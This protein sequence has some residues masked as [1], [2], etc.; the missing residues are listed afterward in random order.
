MKTVHILVVILF[1]SS[2]TTAQK[3][4][5]LKTPDTLAL[6]KAFLKSDH[7][8]N[9]ILTY[10]EKN[11]RATSK[12]T[13]VKTDP[14]FNNIECGF[15]KKFEHGIEYTLNQCGEA[16]PVREKITLPKISLAKLKKWV[17]LIH[18]SNDYDIKNKWYAKKNEY[19]PVDKEAG[20]YYTIEQTATK[21]MIHTWCGS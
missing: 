13:D 18:F 11:Y 3:K 2:L 1:C 15:T 21:S 5:T 12:K 10:L 6:K 17:E 8:L 20:C 16:T 14:E 4:F 19:G 9:V 7:E